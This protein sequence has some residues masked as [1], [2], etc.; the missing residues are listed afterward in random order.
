[1]TQQEELENQAPPRVSKEDF[2]A[3][4]RKFD[5]AVCEACAVSQSVGVQMAD[6][7]I[8]WS[9]HVFARMCI[10][11]NILIANVP[12]SRWAKKDY[13][14][15]D[16]SLV[17][18]HTRAL[19]EADYLFYYL[20]KKP[21]SDEEWSAKINVMHMN[22]CVKRIEFFTALGEQG[23]VDGFNQQRDEI[24]QR[25]E[26]NSVFQSLDS[27]TKKRCLNGKALTIANR[28]D[29]LTEMGVD[30]KEFKII[31]DLLSHYTHILPMSYYRMEGNGRGTG[32]YNEVDMSYITLSMQWSTDV[33]VK[34]TD[35]M[36]ELFPETGKS[37]K[38]LRSKFSFGPKIKK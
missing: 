12:E 27:S 31:F 3:A 10:H 14:F 37:R 24:T 32:N 19:L 34:C 7:Y 20:S 16:L 15:W 22:D 1:M 29:L 35:K 38:G 11:A 21:V 26:N 5:V 13:P 6:A 36:V 4:L 33:I 30:T 9:T 8:G 18:S 2:Y 25:L 28:D 23:Q 17:A